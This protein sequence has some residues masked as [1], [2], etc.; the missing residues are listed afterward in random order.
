MR[1]TPGSS[2]ADT[3]SKL[4]KEA[5]GWDP[6]K[7]T[8]FSNKKVGWKCKKGHKW[9]AAV[10]NRSRGSGCP[11]CAGRIVEVGVSDLKTTHPVLSSQ[12]DGWNP[13]SFSRG[14]NKKVRWKC[15]KGHKW[16]A[17]ISDRVRGNGCPICAGRYPEKSRNPNK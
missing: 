4:A 6:K 11:T 14:S 2:I 13:K 17:R 16:V 10:A 3:N 1:A 7:Y 12:S 8:V 9:V 5:D 15:K